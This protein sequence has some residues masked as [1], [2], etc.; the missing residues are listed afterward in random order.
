[1][2]QQRELREMG[3]RVRTVA[4][5]L[6]QQSIRG[7]PR[8]CAGRAELLCC[9]LVVTAVAA[10]IIAAVETSANAAMSARTHIHG[11]RRVRNY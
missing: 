4:A 11:T 5:L 2:F 9:C 10:A 3:V 8:S 7:E 6:R 1:M